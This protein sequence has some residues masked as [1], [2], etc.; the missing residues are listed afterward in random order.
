[1]QIVASA[2]QIQV[3]LLGIF[4]NFFFLT[5]F[6]L[7]LVETEDVGLA[8]TEDQQ[9]FLIIFFSPKSEWLNHCFWFP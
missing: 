6:D 1:M 2:Q 9:N 8:D 3:L 5:I 7:R 4:W